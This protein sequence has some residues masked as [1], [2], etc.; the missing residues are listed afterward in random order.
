MVDVGDKA[1]D[2]TVKTDGGGEIS[3]SELR[4][5]NVVLYF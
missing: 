1:P 4:G 2:F 5:K 3:L